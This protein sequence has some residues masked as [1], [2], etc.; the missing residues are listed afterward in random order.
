MK[1][2]EKQIE[3]AAVSMAAKIDKNQCCLF[4]KGWIMGA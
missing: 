4:E 3:D 1:D 2:L